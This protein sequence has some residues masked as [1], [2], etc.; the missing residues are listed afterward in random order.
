MYWTDD[1]RADVYQDL[2]D[3]VD[4]QVLGVVQVVEGSIL[5]KSI[6]CGEGYRCN[7]VQSDQLPGFVVTDRLCQGI[8]HAGR[9]I[10]HLLTLPDMASRGSSESDGEEDRCNFIGSV[11]VQTSL[12]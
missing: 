3:D 4:D 5:P 12:D 11:Q 10:L 9:R 8:S 6:A 7:R 2:A 1:L